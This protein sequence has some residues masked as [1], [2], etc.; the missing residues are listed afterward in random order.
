MKLYKLLTIITLGVG[1]VACND[2]EQIPTNNFTDANYWTSP[3]RAQ[4]VVN[5][6]YSQMY[7]AGKFWGDESLSDN[8]IDANRV[9]D[10][11]LIRRGM[12]TTTIGLFEIGRA[13]CRERV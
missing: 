12:A 6:A 1:A 13:S 3:E 10:Q 9:S 2:M 11:R 4:N 7:D 5:M 8:V